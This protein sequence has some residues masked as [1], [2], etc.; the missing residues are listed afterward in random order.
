VEI[1][2]SARRIESAF[3]LMTQSVRE[4]K[5]VEAAVRGLNA[6]FPEEYATY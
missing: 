4:D 3:F 2:W 6:A 1:F 5:S